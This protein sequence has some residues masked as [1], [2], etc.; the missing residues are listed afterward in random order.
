MAEQAEVVS[1]GA[2]KR[3]KEKKEKKE[4]LVIVD[5]LEFDAYRAT[6][7]RLVSTLRMRN[8]YPKGAYDTS[9]FYI[10][11]RVMRISFRQLYVSQFQM[12]KL[13]RLLKSEF[14]DVAYKYYVEGTDL[15]I[16]LRGE[17]R[18]DE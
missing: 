9:T 10:G 4:E 17:R 6:V 5:F 3:K 12:Q 16:Y 7:Q 14:S 1:L 13:L 18:K 11:R 15:H 2:H 8:R